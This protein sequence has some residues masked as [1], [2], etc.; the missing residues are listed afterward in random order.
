VL[1]GSV[2]R[3]SPADKAG[4]QPGDV[5]LQFNGQTL[6]STHALPLLVSELP[7]GSTAQLSVWH[8]GKTRELK[9]TLGESKAA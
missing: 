4:L 1:V 3:G 2:E 7:P 6:D 5:V 9:V 8:Q